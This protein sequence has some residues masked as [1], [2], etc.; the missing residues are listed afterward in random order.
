M[1]YNTYSCTH[2]TLFSQALAQY[3]RIVRRQTQAGAEEDYA[4]LCSELELREKLAAAEHES[5]NQRSLAGTRRD[6]AD[7]LVA[8]VAELERTLARADDDMRDLRSQ[9]R[10][11]HTR[12]HK[13]SYCSYSVV[14]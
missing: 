9:V 8:Q 2:R 3:S 4:Q 14:D 13:S 6:E 1:H 11:R 10:L 7:R 12:T 5:R